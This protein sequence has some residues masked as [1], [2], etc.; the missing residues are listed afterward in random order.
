MAR[1]GDAQYRK[2]LLRQSTAAQEELN[3]VVA[4]V[5]RVLEGRLDVANTYT[6]ADVR[7]IR[8]RDRLPQSLKER[9]TQ[10]VCA[11]YWLLTRDH[12]RVRDLP[13]NFDDACNLYLFR[14]A[15]CAHI[16]TLEWVAAGSNEQ[17]NVSRVRN[18]LVDLLIAVYGTYFDGLMTQDRKLADIHAIA[19]FMLQTMRPEQ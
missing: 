13:K 17:S 8:A 16:W 10:N 4:S 5:Q 14:Y 12:P 18:D 19:R 11:L 15:L 3:T 2:A 7:A 6:N 9:F 1:D